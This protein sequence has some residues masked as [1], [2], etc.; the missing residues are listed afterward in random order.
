MGYRAIG[1]H[2]EARPGVELALS[3]NPNSSVANAA[4]GAMLLY[5]GQRSQARE[6]LSAAL[7]FDPYGPV[8]AVALGQIAFLQFLDGDYRQ[9][10]EIAQRAVYATL[11]SQPRIATSRRH[12]DSLVASRRREMYMQRALDISPQSLHLHLIP[13][14]MFRSEDREHVLDEVK[15][16]GWQ[17]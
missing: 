10:A 15:K 16:A 13:S 7:R 3:I 1:S 14:P 9:A 8:S 11:I 6:A 12:L 2:E 4:K 5:S 17:G